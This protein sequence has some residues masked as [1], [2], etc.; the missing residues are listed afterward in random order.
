MSEPVWS[1]NT[2]EPAIK[3]TKV[4]MNDFRTN[5]IPA[6]IYTVWLEGHSGDPYYQRRRVPIPVRIQTDANGD[7]DYND[8]GDV[9]VTRDFS[10]NNSVLDGSTSVLGGTITLPIRV[11]TTSAS[12][13]RWGAGGSAVALSWDT[14]SLSDCSLNAEPLGSASI[15][16]SAASVTPTT[17]TGTLS[18]LTITTTGLAQG[19][20]LFTVRATGTNGD[21]QPVTHL[22][23]IRFT[24]ATTE[25]N[26]QYVDIIG[27]TVFEIDS[28]TAND[29]IGHAVS[30]ISADPNDATLRRAQRARLVP[31]N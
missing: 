18:N 7:G 3:G 31:W 12:S 15:S 14:G 23:T 9:K 29:I 11:S 21:G 13:T 5:A 4:D 25:S 10:L 27:F 19:C 22:A 16:F 6:G 24:V 30:G 17:G 26:G 28:I 8:A 2:F 20:Y 1:Q